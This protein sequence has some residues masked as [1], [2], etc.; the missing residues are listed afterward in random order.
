M[1]DRQLLR[2]NTDAVRAGIARKHMDAPIDDFLAVDEEWR[3]RRTEID[4][5][6]AELQKTSK[7]IGAMKARGESADD[8]MAQMRSLSDDISAKEEIVKDLEVKLSSFELLI[9]NLPHE[10]TPDGASG[11]DN[12]VVSVWG[13]KPKFDFQPKP[14]W[15]LCELNGMLDF[16]RGSKL[17]G[18]GFILYKGW[19]ARLER[20]M[21]QFMLDTHGQKHGYTELFTPFLANRATMTGT[22]QLPKFEFDMYRMSEDDLFLIPTAEVPITNVYRDEIL[23]A[24]ALTIKH[25][26]YSG[27]WRREAGAAGRDTRG[28]LRVHQFNKVELVK[29]T[30]PEDS[31][32]E[33]ETLVA[34]ARVILEELGL[35]FRVVELCAGDLSFSNAKCYDLEVWAPGV[36]SY[37]EISSCSNFESFQ[38]RRAQIR[39]KREQGAKAEFVHTLNGSGLATPR[40]FAA[41]V[42]SGQQPDGSILVPTPLRGY[43]GTD[44]IPA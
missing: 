10:S 11:E 23:P 43:M 40:L 29:F 3:R 28:L 8:V 41:L 21:L 19:G 36:G 15:D 20:A 31:Y 24:E 2:T 6:R 18:S 30:K 14:H 9:P 33:L 4:A 34:D 32:A 25:C 26:A 1:L 44:R 22:G 35:H 37:L 42:E 7:E 13:E 38:A 16:E 17:A 27:C 12:P 39:F 5:M